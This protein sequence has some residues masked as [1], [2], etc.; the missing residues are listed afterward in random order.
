MR[1]QV[2]TIL[3]ALVEDFLQHSLLHKAQQNGIL[4]ITV[5]DIRAVAAD[6][7]RSVDDSPFGGGPG[8]VLMAEP[9][10]A[11]VEAADPLRP[12]LLLD[13]AGEPFTQAKARQLAATEGFSL[14]CGRYEGID[15]RIREHLVDEELSLGDFVLNGG[16]VAAM[17]V[18]ESVGR[19]V[20]GVL[21]NPESVAHDSF[22]VGLLDHPHY[23]RPAEFRGMHVPEVLRSGDHGRIARWRLAASLARTVERR[24]DLISERGGLSEAEEELLA[25]FGF[26]YS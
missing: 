24:P 2:F 17:A 1:I 20:P 7:H 10:F 19:L 12:L 21:G 14:L 22:E 11:A 9:V 26:G 6:P 5:H 3:P 4:R 25:E 23:T 15:E 16:E 13:P 8:M 18:M